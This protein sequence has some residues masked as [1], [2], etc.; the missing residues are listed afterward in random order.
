MTLD[1]AQKKILIVD[2]ARANL[3]VLKCILVGYVIVFALN[4]PRALTIATADNPPDLILLDVMMPEM[5][6]YE[7]CRR[8]KADAKTRDIPIIFLTAKNSVEDEAKGLGLGAVDYIT[9]PISPPVVLARV[10]THLAMRDAYLQLERQYADLQE[11]DNLRKDVE[12]IS[13]HDLKS[14]IDGI[15]GC[16][17]L[18]LQNE[19]LSRENLNK[20]FRLIRNSAHQLRE[21]A[22]LSLNLIKMER[23]SYSVALQPTDLLPIIRRIFADNQTMIARK[24]IEIIVLVHGHPEQQQESFI[25]LGDETLCYTMIANVCKNALEAAE[26][27]QTVKI[28]L[29]SGDMASISVHNQGV[30]P[31][32]IRERFFDKYVTSGKKGGTGLG[33]YSARLMAETQNGGIHLLSSEEEGTMITITLRTVIGG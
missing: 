3:D 12:A 13:R 7:V 6:G 27:G 1:L 24:N 30:V 11:M 17:N 2:D 22:N 23:G 10:A 9:K 28:S 5:D 32:E 8:L 19:T 20:F 29:D 25:V 21:I 16:T 33:T 15:I 26:K 4:G 18:L 31:E 14:P